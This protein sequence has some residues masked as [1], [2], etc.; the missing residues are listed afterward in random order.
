MTSAPT[1]AR[2][3]CSASISASSPQFIQNRAIRR[4]QLD[5]QGHVSQGVGGT[6]QARV[7]SAHHRFHAVEHPFRKFL[8]IHEMLRHLQNARD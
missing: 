7:K 5:L 1:A 8:A 2:Y 6:T 3:N 4:Q